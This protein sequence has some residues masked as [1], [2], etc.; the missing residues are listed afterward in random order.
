MVPGKVIEASGC[1]WD[2]IVF[3]FTD[4]ETEVQRDKGIWP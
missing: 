3:I 2:G 1:R 4:E